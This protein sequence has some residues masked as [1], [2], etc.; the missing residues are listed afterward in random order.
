MLDSLKS[1]AVLFFIYILYIQQP[2]KISHHSLN[3][4]FF[5]WHLQHFAH[6]FFKLRRLLSPLQP[7]E[8]TMHHLRYTSL[9]IC[10]ALCLEP[11]PSRPPNSHLSFQSQF[12]CCFLCSDQEMLIVTFLFVL[13]KLCLYLYYR[14][15]EGN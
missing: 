9:S 8:T 1:Y 2:P 15:A 11:S 12:Q 3:T 5:F 7:D 4:F 6:S 10:F 14:K 13:T